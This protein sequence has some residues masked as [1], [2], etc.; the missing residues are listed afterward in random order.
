[1]QELS[2]FS[3]STPTTNHHHHH[4]RIK[5]VSI[6]NQIKSSF[7]QRELVTVQLYAL[8]F[9]WFAGKCI[10]SFTSSVDGRQDT[11][12]GF[13]YVAGNTWVR[14]ISIVLGNYHTIDWLINNHLVYYYFSSCLALLSCFCKDLVLM[15]RLQLTFIRRVIMWDVSKQ[16]ANTLT[17]SDFVVLQ[18]IGKLSLLYPN[19]N[20]R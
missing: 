18:S 3:L 5:S 1:M 15:M 10:T 14:V 9:L 20:T 2:R 11:V 7:T 19:E 13:C 8:F 6:S 16:L 17:Y 4:H 12:T